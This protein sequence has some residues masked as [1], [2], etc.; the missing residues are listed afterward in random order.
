MAEFERPR[1]KALSDADL[2]RALQ[3]FP[4]DATG[5][6]LA[7]KLIAEQQ[8][9]REQDSQEL[10]A[11]I[12][13]LR[14][15]D[16]QQSRKILSESIAS[17]LPPEQVEVQRPTEEPPTFTSQL[18]VITRRGKVSRRVRTG[19]L[20]RLISN[21][22]LLAVA[23]FLVLEWLEIEGLSAILALT[24]GMVAAT[25]ISLPLKIHLMHPVLRA[26]AV[27]GGIGVYAFAG[28][29]LAATT[30][31]FVLAF[32]DHSELIDLAYLGPYSAVLVAL[33]AG[34]AL[35]GQ[36]IPVRFGSIAILLPTLTA[37][38]FLV[39]QDV[40]PSFTTELSGG[41]YWGAASVAVVSTLILVIATP[42]TRINWASA[43]WFAPLTVVLT[44]A[45][46]FFTA[47]SS[48]I[49]LT[50]LTVAIMLGLV[51]SGRDLAGGALGRF[52]G[53]SLLIGLI[54]SPWVDLLSGVTIG[55]VSCAFVLLL[56]DQL[57]RTS[58]LHIASLDTSYGFYGAISLV[59]WSALVLAGV[60]GTPWFTALLPDTFN[61]LEWSLVCGLSIGILFGLLRIP[62]IRRQ[63][64]EIKNVDSSSGNI[65]NLL[66]L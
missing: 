12:E 66:G 46:G 32:A 47:F 8:K 15:R 4:S 16:D 11:W 64:R 29:I 23:N 34:A 6:E 19:Q 42:H 49:A 58:P 50:A 2:A 13:L 62:V 7:G 36:V 37:A 14:A 17:I 31:V 25:L 60:A 61:H 54:L 51:F 40:S 56:L 43:A 39:S 28:I 22:I 1:A 53:L 21:A 45:F 35:L 48:D 10:Q 52:A 18:P 24:L 38:F 9:L 41:W 3:T 26:A 65:E 44:T 30:L 27:F 57:S 5:I 63:D 59:S 20:L 55:I 33:V